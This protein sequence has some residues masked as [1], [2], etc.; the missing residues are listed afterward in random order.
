MC[1]HMG[2]IKHNIYKVIVDVKIRKTIKKYILMSLKPIPEM[3]VKD[4]K[5][6]IK[7]YSKSNYIMEKSSD[8]RFDYDVYIWL[9]IKGNTSL[10]LLFFLKI[11]TS[12]VIY[13]RR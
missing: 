3:V 11:S 6:N 8:S 9:T 13:L 2:M 4:F 5:S 1:G 7:L 12:M 10:P